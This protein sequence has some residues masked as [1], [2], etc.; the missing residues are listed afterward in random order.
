MLNWPK[1]KPAADTATARQKMEIFLKELTGKSTAVI[2]QVCKKLRELNETQGVEF[3]VVSMADE[4]L[5]HRIV[6]LERNY[7]HSEEHPEAIASAVSAYCSTFSEAYSTVFSKR[8]Q[9]RPETL[10]AVRAMRAHTLQCRMFRLGYREPRETT[11]KA[12]VG[13]FTESRTAG[14]VEHSVTPYGE[15]PET[16]VGNEFALYALFETAPLQSFSQE[17]IEYFWRVLLLYSGRI[18]V[19]SASGGLVPF[20]IG[21]NGHTYVK[22]P[23]GVQA[24]YHVGP[25]IGT[26]EGISQIAS[27]KKG[28]KH[29]WEA[30]DYLPDVKEEKLV[31]MANRVLS[32]W[33]GE[34]IRRRSERQ[35]S[36]T[37]APVF[38]AHGFSLVRK[39]VAFSAYVNA[40]GT[41]AAHDAF[42]L[43]QLQDSLRFEI[44]I[45]ELTSSSKD[46]TD[47]LDVLNLLE[48]H[49]GGDSTERWHVTDRSESGIGLLASGNHPWL[50]VGQIIAVRGSQ[51]TD[52][53]VGI[54]RRV[55]LKDN[56]RSVGVELLSRSAVAVGVKAFEDLN[57]KLNWFSLHDGILVEGE[58]SRLIVPPRKTRGEYF[59]TAGAGKRRHVRLIGKLP[60]LI[61]AEAYSCVIEA[62]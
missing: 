49:L 12:M 55:S 25:G 15:E 22:L 40:G 59:V 38:I 2:P 37:P 56:A 43:L 58:E 9:E 14:I 45:T 30:G 17:Q 11:L 24:A 8:T 57:E 51:E 6:E 23:S 34:E 28:S 3:T 4:Y 46:V 29:I 27:G 54:V 48:Y 5:R 21:E 36:R 18:P 60:D 61:E 10:S 52:W 35:V 32:V 50:A 19:K 1:K 31:D 53:R 47:P 33:K 13:L 42:R 26:F 41:L 44:P 39:M 62:V 16:S 7:F 20:P